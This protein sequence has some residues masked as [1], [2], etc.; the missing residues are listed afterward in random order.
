MINLVYTNKSLRKL[1]HVVS[2]TDDNELSVPRTLLD[3]PCD[4]GD[5]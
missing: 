1:K 2:E 4:N 3:I 5:L